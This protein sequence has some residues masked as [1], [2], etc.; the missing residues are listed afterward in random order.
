[1]DFATFVES[2]KAKV[3]SQERRRENDELI[4]FYGNLFGP[5]NIDSLSADEFKSF[6][7]FTNNKHWIAIHRQSG[8]LTSD[9]ARLREALAILV[10]EERPIRDRLNE[11]FP[12][13]QPSFIKGLGRAVATPIL[14]VVYPNR[15]GVFNSRSE[16]ALK[17]FGL[18][19]R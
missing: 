11:L 19:R 16:Y 9:M 5:E 18:A 14:T 17:R 4:R 6:L 15:Y 12:K 10:D 13:G 7:S 2:Q 8:M 1:M 3:T